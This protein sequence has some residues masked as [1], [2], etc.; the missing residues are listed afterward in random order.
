MSV[1]AERNETDDVDGGPNLWCPI[2]NQTIEEAVNLHVCA[3]CDRW[4]ALHLSKSEQRW[5][6]TLLENI[7]RKST[8]VRRAVCIS[9]SSTGS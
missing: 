6:S 1:D 5:Q 8:L 4:Q 3:V 7:R 2:C 9:R